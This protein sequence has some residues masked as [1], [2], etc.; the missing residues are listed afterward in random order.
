MRNRHFLTPGWL[1][2][3]RLTTLVAALLIAFAAA[4][5]GDEASAQPTMTPGPNAFADVPGIVDPDNFGWPRIVET[6]EGRMEIP[7]PP[8]GIYSLSLGHAEIIVALTGPGR[9]AGST[10]FFKDPGTS[11]AW[12]Q[13][14]GLPEAG[15]DAEKII[16]LDP[17]LIVAASFTQPELTEQLKGIGLPVVRAEL[18][19]SILGNV[20]NI[21]LLGYMLGEEDRALALVGE[22]RRRINVIESRLAGEDGDRPRVLA[23][24]RFT[25][26][27][28]AGA[29]STEGG[30][31]EAAGGINA[32]AESGIESHQEASI[33]S[34]VAIN[35]DIILL[36]Q[37]E[38]SALDLADELYAEPA[39][40]EVPAIRDRRVLY[41]DPTYYTTLSHWNV[42]GIEES[43]RAF[44]PELFSD[45]EFT[46][47]APLVE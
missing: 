39:L 2:Q 17:D 28:V 42:R 33:E 34:I 23:A 14:V 25:S 41:G 36:T 24:S 37:P 9:L 18:E 44:F 47:F 7:Q 8:Q 4:C 20:P 27:F 21:L 43:A 22:V 15:S 46:D 32:A 11:A 10:S 31:I 19:S 1:S 13:F 3:L 35:P 29:G 30:I 45:V 38:E 12:E 16:A 40:A 5:G 6:S 26:I